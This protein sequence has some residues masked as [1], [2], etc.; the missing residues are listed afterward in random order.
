MQTIQKLGASRQLLAA[1]SQHGLGSSSSVSSM[2]KSCEKLTGVVTARGESAKVGWFRKPVANAAHD[3]FE[4]SFQLAVDNKLFALEPNVIPAVFLMENSVWIKAMRESLG[5]QGLFKESGAII[6][7]T[8]NVVR[9]GNDV[10]A[11]L[12]VGAAGNCRADNITFYEGNGLNLITLPDENL[13]KYALYLFYPANSDK[14][15]LFN[16]RKNGVEYLF[17]GAQ[18]YMQASFGLVELPR[19]S[20]PMFLR[21]HYANSFAAIEIN[22]STGPVVPP[23][24]NVTLSSRESARPEVPYVVPTS[25]RDLQDLNSTHGKYAFVRLASSGQDTPEYQMRFLPYNQ[26]NSEAHHYQIVGDDQMIA[27]GWWRLVEDENGSSLKIDKNSNVYG[28]RIN[29]EALKLAR[30]TMNQQLSVPVH[31]ID[32]RVLDQTEDD[33]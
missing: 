9:P 33:N 7:S 15:L 14:A 23:E 18:E 4:S 17:A 13:P 28:S 6:S 19:S 22:S 10:P 8:L 21:V 32:G 20:E 30:T 31:V 16:L 29:D 25:I 3:L 26:K 12:C 5:D 24:P 27:A 2:I 1:A 11:G